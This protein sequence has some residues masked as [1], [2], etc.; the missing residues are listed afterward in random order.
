VIYLAVLLDVILSRHAPLLTS[1]LDMIEVE[2][3]TY[4]QVVLSQRS[5]VLWPPPTPLKASL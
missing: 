4:R 5:S 1:S 3:L 2:A